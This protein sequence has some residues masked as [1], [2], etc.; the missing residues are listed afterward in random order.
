[1]KRSELRRIPS[2]EKIA[3]ALGDTRLPRPMVLDVVRRDLG[4]LRKQKAIPDFDAVLARV[5]AAVVDLAASRIQPVINGTGILIH[6]N[7]GRAPLSSLAIERLAQIGANYNNIEYDLAAGERGKRAAYLERSLALLCGAESAVAVNNNAAALILI[8]RHFCAPATSGGQ[9][10]RPV[11]R[12]KTAAPSNEVVISRGEL[13]QIGGGFRIPEILE[14]SGARLREV[15]TTNQT[16]LSDYARAVN[17]STA[18]ILKVHRSNFFMG[19]FVE[20]PGVEDLA[21]LARK[22]RVPLAEDL[23]SGAA[24][25]TETIAGVGHEPTPAESIRHG[26]DLVCFSGDKLLGG[27]QAGVIA[28]K[29][30]LVEA[31]KRDPFF[32]ALRCSKLILVALEATVETYLCAGGEIRGAGIPVIEMLRAPH[33]ELYARA[34][35]IAAALAGLPIRAAIG[36]GRA[37]VG[38]GTMPASAID[39][40]TIDLT[41][42]TIGAQELAARLRG[43]TTPMIGYISHSKLKLDVRTIFPH[44]D[45]EVVAAIRAAAALAPEGA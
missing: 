38:G 3:Q 43:H 41:H 37:Q 5:R 24:I 33:D 9:L 21:T 30:K 19:G 23:G 27:P 8:L 17:P 45:A 40:V 22:K 10:R 29:T 36:R 35:K 15:G 34:T 1:M 42:T 11:G 14:S 13:I 20:S 18:F 12:N 32:R 16:T 31:I 6:T 26:V 28:G 7:F 25:D 2:V 4:T 39:S 44:Q